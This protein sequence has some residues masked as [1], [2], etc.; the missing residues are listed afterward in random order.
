[1][2]ARASGIEVIFA[3]NVKAAFFMSIFRIPCEHLQPEICLI[4]PIVRGLHN[5]VGVDIYYYLYTSLFYL[6]YIILCKA[7]DQNF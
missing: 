3:G 4:A 7:H 2:P 1:M 6:R 5:V